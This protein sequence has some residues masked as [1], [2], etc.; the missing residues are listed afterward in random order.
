MGESPP[1]DLAKGRLVV[2]GTDL[3]PAGFID[4]EVKD[5]IIGC[6]NHATQAC[7]L[8]LPG[9]ESRQ[10][11]RLFQEILMHGSVLVILVELALFRQEDIGPE[12]DA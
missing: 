9:V 6:R 7:L 8:R 11:D 5:S 12:L 1:Q 10:P 4:Q 2:M 3:D